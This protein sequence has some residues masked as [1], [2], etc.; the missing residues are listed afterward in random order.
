VVN[1]FDGEERDD[2]RAA[3]DDGYRAATAPDEGFR[4]RKAVFAVWEFA[5]VA[6]VRRVLRN[7]V[8]EFDAEAF[9]RRA[10]AEFEDRRERAE[11]RLELVG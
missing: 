8:D 6:G 11:A 1:L 4:V 7:T 5:R 10:E 2:H 9:R 3:L